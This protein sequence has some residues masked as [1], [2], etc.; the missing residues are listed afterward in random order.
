V[1]RSRFAP[2]ASIADE[3]VASLPDGLPSLS[4]LIDRVRAPGV[5]Q[6]EI[7]ALLTQLDQPLAPQ[8][9]PREHADLLLSLI[10]DNHVSSFTGSDGRTVR[11]AALQA[12]LALGYPYALEV[13]P[14]ALE[15]Q[16]L[17]AGGSSLLSTRS[18]KAALTL[19]G[20]VALLGTILLVIDRDPSRWRDHHWVALAINLGA[21]VF[22]AFLS[23]LGHDLRLRFLHHVGNMVLGLTGVLLM[24]LGT[25]ML[26]SG[27]GLISLLPVLAGLSQLISGVLLYTPKPRD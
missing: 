4:V 6:V 22:P 20:L 1:D 12:L 27:E 18:G 10:E 26:G 7:D 14:E 2:P 15:A 21:T 5:A 17:A 13:P 16:A 11:A 19:T 9:S 24:G 8:Q 25:L 3:G 23:I